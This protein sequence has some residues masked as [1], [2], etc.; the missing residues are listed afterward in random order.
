MKYFAFISYNS[1]DLSWGKR[2]QRKLEHYRMPATIC[3][4]HGWERCPLQ[5]IFFAPTDIQPG[6]LSDE[7]KA[8]LEESRH[9]IVI[10]SPRSAAS[11]WVG[12]EIE[13]FHRL[14][15]TKNIHLFIIE[16]TANSNNP[17]TECLNPIIRQLDIP[18]ILGANIHERIYPWP[19]L[20]RER[21]YVQLVS[22]LLGIEFDT[23]WNR[24]RRLLVQKTIAWSL[25]GIGFITGLLTVWQANKPL[26]VAISVKDISFHNPSLPY[27]ADFVVR[28][29]LD[30]EQKTDTIQ[31]VEQVAL[32]SNIPHR[33][34]KHMVKITIAGKTFL[35]TDT[36]II[37]DQHLEVFLR[38]DPDYFG[39]IHF[40]LL[41]A[42]ELTPLVGIP[43]SVGDYTFISGEDG[44][45][46]GDIPVPEQNTQYQVFTPFSNSPD[47]VMM[48]SGEDDVIVID[49]AK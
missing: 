40:R 39:H 33:F 37:L 20:N 19:W 8:R 44:L 15:R 10:C 26:D 36:T 42:P 49:T 35:P 11:T 4:E 34:L 23:L 43:V 1:K 38:R 32:F 3:S 9:L 31:T 6:A 46:E 21:A 24:H 17:D 27:P 29:T 5:P 13:Y 22:K 7:L 16:G 14:G 30:N 12:R 25:L 47:I 48:P 45:V 18:E 28:L 41:R 2:L